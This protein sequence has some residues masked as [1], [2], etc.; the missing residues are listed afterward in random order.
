MHF[1][2]IVWTI[3]FKQ[4]P[5]FFM[6]TII[7]FIYLSTS[8][9]CFTQ[10][11]T[12]IYKMTWRIDNRLTTAFQME[13]QNQ[14]IFRD[15]HTFR[16]PEQHRDAVV[17]Q[18]KSII[19]ELLNTNSQ[20]VFRKRKNGNRIETGSSQ[21]YVGGL[22]RSTK[23]KAI[24]EFEQDLYAKVYINVS[25]Y[26]SNIVGA[27]VLNTGVSRFR[28]FVR[29]KIKAYGSDRKRVYRKKIKLNDFE[30][31]RSVS[32]TVGGTTVRRSQ[33][34]KDYEIRDMVIRA[35]KSMSPTVSP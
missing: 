26:R 15:V 20:L 1:R 21:E 28:P 12:G 17:D 29:I 3:N 2:H 24:K 34:L 19:N 8:I 18:V 25:A 16:M 4:R 13:T 32:Y 10:H 33:T 30:K 35:L 7:L 14:G 31:L 5:T 11:S 22:P 6:K 23:R 27:S 9:Y